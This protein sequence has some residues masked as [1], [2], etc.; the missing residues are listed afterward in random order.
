MKLN[1][2][3]NLNT[4]YLSLILFFNEKR[5]VQEVIKAEINSTYTIK[6]IIIIEY[7]YIDVTRE[8]L[9]EKIEQTFKNLVNKIIYYNFNV[10]NAIAIICVLRR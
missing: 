10:G 3:E 4:H 8:I 9:K 5:A 2:L 1:R 6:E 7:S